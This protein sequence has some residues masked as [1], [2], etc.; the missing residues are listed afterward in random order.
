MK[1]HRMINKTPDILFSE[2]KTV[3]PDQDRSCKNCAKYK[4]VDT[5]K[6]LCYEYEV[7]PQAYCKFFSPKK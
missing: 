7:L 2:Y 4:P 1:G 6:G 3:A 5:M